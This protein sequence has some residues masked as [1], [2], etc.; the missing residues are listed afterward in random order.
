MKANDLI[1]PCIELSERAVVIIFPDGKR[2]A[3]KGWDYDFNEKGE[4]V[5]ALKAGRKIRDGLRDKGVS[6]K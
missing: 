3:V 2:L 1:D 6:T 4:P 5:L